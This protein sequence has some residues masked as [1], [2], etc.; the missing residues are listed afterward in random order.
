VS[1]IS[2]MSIQEIDALAAQGVTVAEGDGARH[3][4]FAVGLCQ[5]WLT[6]IFFTLSTRT[7]CLCPAY[8]HKPFAA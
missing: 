3:Q 5:V 4:V 1:N 7:A 2:D 6:L 8:R